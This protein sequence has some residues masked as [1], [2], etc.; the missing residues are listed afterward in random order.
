M[1]ERIILEVSREGSSSVAE[2]YEKSYNQ[3]SRKYVSFPGELAL[4]FL[5]TPRL[6]GLHAPIFMLRRIS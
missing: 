4:I 6:G 1:G 3:V 5:E 2:Q